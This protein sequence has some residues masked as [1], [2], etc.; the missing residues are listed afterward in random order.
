MLYSQQAVEEDLYSRRKTTVVDAYTRD[1]I[2]YYE[3]KLQN[4]CSFKPAGTFLRIWFN[5]THRDLYIS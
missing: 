4:I 1:Q 2:G 5:F 3:F